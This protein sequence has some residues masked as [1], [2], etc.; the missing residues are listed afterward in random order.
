MWLSE[1]MMLVE[2]DINAVMDL[3][4]AT[5]I[6]EVKRLWV[7]RHAGFLST[8]WVSMNACRSSGVMVVALICEPGASSAARRSR[9][10]SGSR[11]PCPPQGRPS[12]GQ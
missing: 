11:R 12:S 6:P 9:T 5:G 7:L 10:R 2:R 1:P 8:V 4:L 3:L